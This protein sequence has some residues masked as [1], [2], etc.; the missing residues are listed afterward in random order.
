MIRD[1]LRILKVVMLLPV[2]LVAFSNTACSSF[3]YEKTEKRVVLV[4]GE[5]ELKI[6]ASRSDIYISAEPELEDIVLN[7]RR[8]VE[9][10]D[11]DKAN[12]LSEK[13]DVEV[14]REDGFIELKTEFPESEV[15]DKNIFS[16]L[17]GLGAEIEMDLEIRVP[18]SM[19]ISVLTAS[20]DVEL[21]NILLNTRISTSSGD[22]KAENLNG[23]LELDVS[24]ADITAEN[25]GGIVV[26]SVSGDFSAKKVKGD[27][28]LSVTSGDVG[29]VD[30]EGDIVIKTVS[31]DIRVDS[32]RGSATVKGTSGSIDIF[33]VTGAV[34]ALC[35]SGDISIKASPSDDR[36]DYQLGTSSGSVLLR[37][38]DILKGGFILRASTTSG[39]IKLNLPIDVSDVSR[40]NVS[41]VVRD[42]K[43]KVIIETSSG[44][45]S[46][47]E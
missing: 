29:L 39:Q 24:S 30:V 9:A 13:L 23:R 34:R 7:I 37:F 10:A 16:L 31:G 40:N 21:S 1:R 17:L 2:L 12:Q 8:K 46:I 11:E 25:I 32:A 6:T 45:I 22:V 47:E 3:E 41:G 36:V 14:I 28:D 18:E 35:A 27:V 42:G 15:K 26:N 33:G 38:D 44:D 20:G 5:K 43:S 4:H 19:E